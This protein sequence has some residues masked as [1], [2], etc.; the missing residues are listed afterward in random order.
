MPENTEKLIKRRY[1]LIIKNT[2]KLTR[3]KC[4]HMAESIENV[5]RKRGIFSINCIM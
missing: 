1:K 4:G 5:L 2:E 3:K